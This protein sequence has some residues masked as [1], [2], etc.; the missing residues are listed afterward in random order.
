M[1]HIISYHKLETNCF[2]EEANPYVRAEHLLDHMHRRSDEDFARFRVALRKF[3]QEHVILKYL[4]ELSESV[5]ES[6]SVCEST[7][8]FVSHPSE[9]ECQPKQ[10]VT[11]V[12]DEMEVEQQ[13]EDMSQQH[14]DQCEYHVLALPAL[15]FCAFV[16]LIASPH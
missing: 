15:W 14:Q 4:E 12:N 6:E 5:P 9:E 8:V 2:Q 10:L 16:Y 1:H 11:A 3:R 7:K 13:R